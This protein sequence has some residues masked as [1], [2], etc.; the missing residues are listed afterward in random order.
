ML[1]FFIL[2]RCKTRYRLRSY[3][4][5]FFFDFLFSF[6]EVGCTGQKP[7]LQTNIR[8]TYTEDLHYNILQLAIVTF[9]P[10]IDDLFI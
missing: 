6:D 8:Y 2:Q 9:V 5:G 10:L 4:N 1:R 3:E 7:K